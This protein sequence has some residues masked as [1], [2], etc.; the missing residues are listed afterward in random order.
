M[1]AL[2]VAAAG[3]V[4][5]PALPAAAVPPAP[6]TFT[7]TGAEQSY[8]VPP[9]VE[10]LHVVAV[11]GQ[12]HQSL[13]PLF[14]RSG[15]GALVT[16]DVALPVGTTRVF[17]EVGG[18]ADA[19]GDGGWNGGADASLAS[20][21]DAPVG[22]G[23]GG[24]SD[25]RTCSTS[26]ASCAGG[27]S[28][29]QSRVVVAGGGGGGGAAD[30]EGPFFI[31]GR[32]GDAGAADGSGLAGQ[33]GQG[34]S[35]T[36]GGGG[37]GGAS[38]TAPGVGGVPGVTDDSNN[39]LGGLAGA[40]G[41]FGTGGVNGGG[42]GWFGGGGGATGAECA[43]DTGTP[44]GA[45]GGGG[46][47]SSFVVPGSPS[48]SF[49]TDTTGTPS[50]T[51]T[52]GPAIQPPTLPG[53]TSG[54]AYS[55]QLTADEGGDP[56]D[57]TFSVGSG[58]LPPG[59]QLDGSGLL[60]GTPTLGGIFTFAIDGTDATQLVGRRTYTVQ[61]AV[62]GVHIA[63]ATVAPA[64]Q[65][66]AYSQTLTAEFEGLPL[67]DATFS[68][69][70]G[71]LPPGMT[72]SSAGTIT[73]TTDD[74]G[75]FDFTVHASIPGIGAVPQAYTLTV[76]QLEITPAT[77][78]TGHTGTAYS[79]Q[80]AVTFDGTPDTPAAFSVVD[81]ALPPGLTL[82]ASGVLAGTPTI[83]ETYRF[84]VGAAVAGV[85]TAHR[86]YVVD[87]EGLIVMPRTLP[88][89]PVN[90][91]YLEVLTLAFDGEPVDGATFSVTGG[92][93][94]S[95]MQLAPS[96]QL[97]GA[98]PTPGT[99]TFSVT[100]A[101][102]L[103]SASRQ[104][105]LVVNTPPQTFGWA[106]GEQRYVVVPGTTS[107]HIRAVGGNGADTGQGAVGGRG[108]VVDAEVPVRAGVTELFVVVGGNGSGQSG[109]NGGQDDGGG[110][111]SDV[112]T[113]SSAAT[114]CPGGITTLTSRLVVAGGGGAAGLPGVTQ[115]VFPKGGDG[116]NAGTAPDGSGQPGA[117]GTPVVIVDGGRGGG[118]ATSAAG[119]DGGAGGASCAG[120]VSGTPGSE[121]SDGFGGPGGAGGGGGGGG[122]FGGGGGGGGAACTS[123]FR[124]AGS[125][126][127]GAGSSHVDPSATSAAISSRGNEVNAITI[128][129]R[130]DGTPPGSE[131]PGSGTDPDGSSGITP[132]GSGSGAPSGGPSGLAFTGAAP[133]G[134]LCIGA[135]FVLVG[136]LLLRRR[137]RGRAG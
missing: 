71:A 11:G 115:T 123:E 56:V 25:V 68:I 6:H 36:G 7:F 74:V 44:F 99:Y 24:A 79:E 30:E 89:A 70:D 91:D 86:D 50:I 26:A 19:S 131:P 76:R 135:S 42:G 133:T 116:G 43:A 51:I 10:M 95:G 33:S 119:G 92:A 35:H 9:G 57:A 93:L 28:T 136:A 8:D 87:I 75:A 52:P 102:G 20:D 69:D 45:P 81:G 109:S 127:G 58:T 23:G 2:V 100:A 107:V 101:T 67:S 72:L 88:D 32:G 55:Q 90:Q 66:V 94:P 15:K 38:P 111:A 105:Q 137:R 106:P 62:P 22:S 46:A 18:N 27:G 108:A 65:G 85:G 118:G 4:V 17:V 77:L 41:Q 54:V 37:G 1:A 59:L 113:C 132:A 21:P 98:P 124:E 16:T 3:L 117:A 47:G 29:L 48:A 31:G 114:S 64:A 34:D 110:C 128:T 53:G 73:G 122:W 112:R 49:A 129:P 103:G 97:S 13:S 82:S 60:S 14:G 130:F 61:V 39:C 5:A 134:L 120:G 78:A 96:G 121:G 80:L 125:G 84:T 126:G 12:G 83:A 63:P 40:P 104:Y